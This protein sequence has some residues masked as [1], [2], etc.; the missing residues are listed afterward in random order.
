M[1]TTRYG[2]GSILVPTFKVVLRN[3]ALLGLREFNRCAIR[4][5]VEKANMAMGIRGKVDTSGK[6]SLLLAGTGK[7]GVKRVG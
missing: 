2:T 5:N 1:E 4:A 6:A 3:R 7:Y